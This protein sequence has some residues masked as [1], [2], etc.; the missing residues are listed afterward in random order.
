MIT[1]LT[2]KIIGRIKQEGPLS[3]DT[4]MEMALY[5]PGLGYYTRE[6]TEIGKAGD[7]YT[8][9]HLHPLFGAMMGRQVMEM[10]GILGAPFDVIEMGAGIGHLC[11]DMLSYLKDKA[12]FKDLHYT[13]VE[14]NPSLR[15]RQEELLRE[16]A[17][18]VS[19]VSS[20]GELEPRRGCLISNELPDAFPVRLI[21]MDEEPMEIFVSWDGERFVELKRPADKDIMD[22]LRA[23][24]EDLPR[25]YRTELNLKIK[26]WLEDISRVISEGFIL[27]VD[28]GYPAAEYYSEERNR[29]TLL[30]YHRHTVNEDPYRN[31]GEQD[32]TAH[33]NFSALKRWGEKLGFHV[34]GFCPQGTY[35]VSLGIDEVITDLY[36][37]APDPFA[38][39]QIK[40]LILPQGMGESH[41]VMIQYKG[42]SSPNLRGFSLRNQQRQL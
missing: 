14:M 5:E 21:E 42:I 37:N 11:H 18:T 6:E 23:F 17:D 24:A 1:P 10:Q 26:G 22:Y 12:G 36:G 15:R 29:G 34:A 4:F 16:F 40:G 38:I 31:I 41:M 2:Q 9:P 20:L 8:S 32:I 28:Y 13:I 7:F 3:F 39:A 35:L 33:V 25:G 27:T 30:C 19:W